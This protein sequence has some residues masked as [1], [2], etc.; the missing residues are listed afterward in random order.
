MEPHLKVS[1]HF[2][3]KSLRDELQGGSENLKNNTTVCL[4]WYAGFILKEM[5]KRKEVHMKLPRN[6]KLPFL[7]D[8][9]E[10]NDYITKARD[11]VWAAGE[12]EAETDWAKRKVRKSATNPIDDTNSVI[13][14]IQACVQLGLPSIRSG[15][16]Q[17]K[18]KKSRQA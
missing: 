3:N 18:P 10:N 17:R 11:V 13:P 7:G 2:D 8:G 12:G 6:L 4:G 9:W 1:D 5:A 15:R 16:N 14:S